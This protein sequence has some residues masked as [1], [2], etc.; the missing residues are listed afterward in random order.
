MLLHISLPDQE[1]VH[2]ADLDIGGVHRMGYAPV[3]EVLFTYTPMEELA[4]AQPQAQLVIHRREPELGLHR[5][6][7]HRHHVRHEGLPVLDM[8]LIAQNQVA[9]C[10]VSPK[11]ITE[12]KINI[13]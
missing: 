12:Y 8:L 4:L 5:R 9:L 11:T 3:S 6:H 7:R 10:E 2:P 1:F 13:K